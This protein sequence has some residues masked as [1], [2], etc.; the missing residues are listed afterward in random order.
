MTSTSPAFLQAGEDLDRCSERRRACA[1]S[2]GREQSSVGKPGLD[3]SV[4]KT[5]KHPGITDT[6]LFDAL[7]HFSWCPPDTTAINGVVCVDTA[8]LSSSILR[9]LLPGA[10]LL[11]RAHLPPQGRQIKFLFSAL[12]WRG[13]G[14]GKQRQALA[15]QI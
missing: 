14:G 8:A 9:V 4:Q 2:A 1:C 7:W 10:P 11:I 5:F 12:G 13:W 15:E 6:P 3:S